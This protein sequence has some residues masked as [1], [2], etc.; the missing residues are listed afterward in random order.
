MISFWQ[1]QAVRLRAVEAEDWQFFFAWSTDTYFE[2]YTDSLTFP[3]SRDAVKQWAAD[4]ATSDPKDDEFRWVI[5]NL[6][7]ECVGTINTYTCDPRKGTFQYGIAICREHW[8]KGYASEAIRLV[9]GFFFH[10]LRYQKVNVHIYDFN[11]DSIALH[12]KLGFQHEGR[13]RRMGFTDGAYFDWVL[14]G[15]TREE[16]KASHG[17]P[18]P[19]E[20]TTSPAR[21]ADSNREGN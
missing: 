15:L 2:R 20:A 1:G 18:T 9:L 4:Q 19:L 17:T 14:M 6:D 8:H 16:F 5:E 13:L 10:E 21:S 12:R 7:G 11:S 3:A